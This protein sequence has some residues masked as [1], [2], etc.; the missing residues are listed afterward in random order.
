MF[1]E[2]ADKCK[3]L[4][5]Q[6]DERI[7]NWTNL[8]KEEFILSIKDSSEIDD[9]RSQYQNETNFKEKI[10]IKKRIDELSDRQK[11]RE[12]SFHKTVGIIEKEAKDMKAQFEENLLKR[13]VLFTK[14]VVKF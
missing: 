4:I 12:Q 13:P 8:R 7:E 1:Q 10:A 11:E 14:I 6:N 5:S 2:H 9:L 3:I